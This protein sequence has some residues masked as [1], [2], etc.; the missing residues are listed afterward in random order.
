M[1]VYCRNGHVIGP[2][3]LWD[4]GAGTGCYCP[5]CHAS[6]SEYVTADPVRIWPVVLVVFLALTLVGAWWW[7]TWL[8]PR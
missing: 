5:T 6:L 7:W 1:T 8:A 3:V 2:A 4:A